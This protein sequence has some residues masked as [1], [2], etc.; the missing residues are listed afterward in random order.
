[1]ALGL[2]TA[3]GAG[4]QASQTSAEVTSAAPTTATSK[5]IARVA[6]HA[7]NPKDWTSAQLGNADVRSRLPQLT[8]AQEVGARTGYAKCNTEVSVK[9]LQENIVA[10]DVTDLPPL[11]SGEVSPANECFVIGL[12]E[13]KP[14]SM[15][16]GVLCVKAA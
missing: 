2:T 15:I 7:T 6:C 9:Q 10:A 12:E 5:A 1:L 4:E 16:I 13:G 3:C 8:T 14:A 11:P